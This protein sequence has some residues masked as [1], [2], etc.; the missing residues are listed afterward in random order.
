MIYRGVKMGADEEKKR[1]RRDW[2]KAVGITVL[3]VAA[4]AAFV[5]G[6]QQLGIR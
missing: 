5:L 2:L 1:G 3:V 6:T 4:A